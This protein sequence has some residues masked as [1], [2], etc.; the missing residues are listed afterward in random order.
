MQIDPGRLALLADPSTR[1]GRA[2]LEELFAAFSSDM[3]AKLERIRSALDAGDAAL[4]RK[5]AHEQKGASGM[6]GAA[7]VARLFVE[8]EGASDDRAAVERALAQVEA[9]LAQVDLE[10]TTFLCRCATP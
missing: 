5:I 4:V 10:V 2:S 6:V 3:H 1:A 8:I 9:D 7:G